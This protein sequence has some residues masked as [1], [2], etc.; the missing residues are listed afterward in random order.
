VKCRLALIIAV[1]AV[2][3]PTTSSVSG[4]VVGT[5]TLYEGARLI[6]GE[7]GAAIESSA[8]IVDNDRFVRVGKMGEIAERAEFC[9]R[10][11]LSPR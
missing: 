3:G 9:L 8:F 5:V 2:Y 10:S 6:T 1:A 11:P 4:Q 7:P